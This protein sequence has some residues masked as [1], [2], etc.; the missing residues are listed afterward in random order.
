MTFDHEKLTKVIS[1]FAEAPAAYMYLLD[2][3]YNTLPE[4]CKQHFKAHSEMETELQE[5]HSTLIVLA[6]CAWHRSST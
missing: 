4:E 6:D 1:V 2:K 3:K 5:H